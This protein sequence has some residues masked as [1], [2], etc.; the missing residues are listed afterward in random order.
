M[1]AAGV[2][3]FEGRGTCSAVLIGPSLVATAAHCL[4][5]FDARLKSGAPSTFFR[6]GAYPG[7]ESVAREI[8]EVAKHPFFDSENKRT[9]RSFGSD[10]AL[11]RLARPIPE[12]IAKP[13]EIGPTV[14]IGE[15]VLIASYA[16]GAGERARERMCPALDRVATLT[17]LSCLVKSGESGAPVVRLTET[18]PQ[19]AGI[20][21]ATGKEGHQPFAFVVDAETRMRQLR[22]IYGF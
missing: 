7:H 8:A 9:E 14:E 21:V 10:I 1:A 4:G 13:L 11:A 3:Q 16:G 15:R 20:L 12:D 18:G 17:R 2:I 19:L 22:A 6:T 5:G